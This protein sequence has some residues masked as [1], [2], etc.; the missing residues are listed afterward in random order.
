M[1]LGP[2]V[3]ADIAADLDRGTTTSVQLAG[4]ALDALGS[5]VADLHGLAAALP[6]RG[7]EAAARA[8]HQRT[9]ESTPLAGIPFAVKDIFAASGAP[10]TWGSPYFAEQIFA[11]DARV[12]R[13]L[14]RAGA[15]LTAKLAMSELAGYGGPTAAGASLQGS[16]ANPWRPDCYAGGSSGGSAIAVALDAVPFALGTETAGSVVG[17]AALCGVTGFRPTPGRISR[18][19][20]LTLSPTLDKVGILARTAQDC[21]TV[22]DAVR[23]PA[24]PRAEE[25]VEVRIGIVSDEA[26][27]WDAEIA[28]ALTAALAEFT[29]LGQPVQLERDVLGRPTEP[30]TT[31]MLSEAVFTLHDQLADPAFRLIDPGQDAGLRSG[32]GIPATEYLAALEARRATV[33]AFATVFARCDVIVAATRTDTARPL[34][35]ARGG[36]RSG[37]ADRLRGAANLAGLPGVSVPAGLSTRGLPVGLHVV[38]ARGKDDLALRLAARYQR[39]TTHHELRPPTAP[40]RAQGVA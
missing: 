23:R 40:T 15:V 39:S 18:E 21:A 31:I 13:Q 7:F 2:S 16:A 14:A 37:V 28:P 34:G 11:R 5:A 26:D 6:E 24:R 3:I 27:D 12:V 1:R 32:T 9:P 33:R 30:L 25:P 19:G 4:R 35:A 10:T 22:F 8:D 20:V 17:P 38:A 29:A 36:S